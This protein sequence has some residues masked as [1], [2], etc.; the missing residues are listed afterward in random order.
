MRIERVGDTIR[1]LLEENEFSL[2]LMSVSDYMIYGFTALLVINEFIALGSFVMSLLSYL[3]FVLL[4]LAFAARKYV[5]L[6][7]L[8]GGY[9]FTNAYQLVERLITQHHFSWSCLFGIFVFTLLMWLSV[10]LYRKS[11]PEKE[12]A[13]AVPAPAY[14]ATT[15]VGGSLIT[16]ARL[17]ASPGKETANAD[18]VTCPECGAVYPA[19]AAFCG[20]CG[21]SFEHSPD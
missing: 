21:H 8:F 10:S 2:M 19:N 7:V 1:E 20:K 16:P 11:L 12:N 18:T 9:L 4:V 13:P 6:S 15:P 14:A 17:S 3:F 5:S